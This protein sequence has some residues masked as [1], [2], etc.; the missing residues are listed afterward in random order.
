VGVNARL[1]PAEVLA[2]A[3]IRRLDGVDTGEYFDP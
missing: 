1:M 2:R 3:R